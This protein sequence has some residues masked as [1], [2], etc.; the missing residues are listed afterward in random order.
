[1]SSGTL[2][3]LC[4]KGDQQGGAEMLI[5]LVQRAQVPYYWVNLPLYSS[6]KHHTQAF[7]YVVICRTFLASEAEPI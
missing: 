4:P 3:P 7:A 6:K 5:Q 2:G 1:M